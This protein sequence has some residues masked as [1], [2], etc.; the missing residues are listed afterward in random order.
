MIRRYSDGSHDPRELDDS[1]SLEKG[2]RLKDDGNSAGPYRMR[3]LDAG[4]VLGR[5]EEENAGRDECTA[6]RRRRRRRS[7]ENLLGTA[8]DRKPSIPS[9][10]RS[11]RKP[12]ALQLHPLTL[13]ALSIVF[14]PTTY[15]APPPNRP[16]APLKPPT[17]H[18]Y[19]TTQARHPRRSSHPISSITSSSGTTATSVS[20]VDETAMPY[21]LT[22]VGDGTWSKIDNAWYLYGRQAG[23]SGI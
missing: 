23:V 9:P 6:C 8:D 12:G 19:P 18:P 2:S 4:K 7:L 11:P 16:M 21:V 15:A 22:Q 10:G 13:S 3:R 17:F 14:F 1:R 5:P 20:V